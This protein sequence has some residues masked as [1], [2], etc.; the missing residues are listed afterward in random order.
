MPGAKEGSY[1]ELELMFPKRKGKQFTQ[2]HF[3]TDENVFAHV[4]FN[5]RIDADGKR[6]LFIEEL[7]SDWWHKGRQ[8]GFEK[9]YINGDIV[10]GREESIPP[11]PF[12]SKQKGD[13]FVK[14]DKWRAL[15]MKRMTRWASDNN[16]DRVG[17]ITGRDS[18]DRYN[19]N[20]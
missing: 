5:E 20:T 11:A 16:F 12:V 18:A 13:Q 6:M 14:D 9:P 2:S 4:R 10:G 1:R 8:F 3:E 15:A 19:L 7:Q 17:W